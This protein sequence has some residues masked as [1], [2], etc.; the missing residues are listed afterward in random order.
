MSCARA[1]R[2]A[3]FTVV[4]TVIALTLV[5]LV[6][7]KL[8]LV[9]DEAR[10]AHQQES[11]AMALEDQALELIDRIAFAV[12]GA[13]RE[14]LTPG[15]EAPFP[16]HEIHYQ[17]STG[18]E[19][20]K[21]VWSAPEVIGLAGEGSIYWAENQGE[22][23]ERL[24]VWANTVSQMLQNEVMNGLDDNGNDLADEL[25]LAFVLDGRSVTIR[26]SLERTAD[27]GKKIQ[28]S[29]ETTVTCRN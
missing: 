10:R 5:G 22:A 29:K 8:A 21:S 16:A 17:I 26:L 28:A 12:V 13:A 1:R 4:E 25:G 2:R 20:G 18:V 11:L 6:V 19:D 14:K 3:G 24:V 9:M 7:T 15:M 27:D 23:D